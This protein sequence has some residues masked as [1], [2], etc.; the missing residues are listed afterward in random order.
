MSRRSLDP[1]QLS[2]GTIPEE[3]EPTPTNRRTV[4]D[5]G[6]QTQQIEEIMQ[7]AREFDPSMMDKFKQQTND[8]FA[9]IATPPQ[10]GGTPGSNKS[11]SVGSLTPDSLSTGRYIQKQTFTNKPKFNPYYYCIPNIS[12]GKIQ[13]WTITP[14]SW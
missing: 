5:T 7:K 10:K 8:I 1:Y 9:S 4:G 12:E 11:L 14:S 2:T 3:R 13:C 6:C